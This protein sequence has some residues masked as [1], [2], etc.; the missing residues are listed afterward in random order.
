M[1]PFVYFEESTE[2]VDWCF[3]SLVFAEVD[4]SHLF[5]YAFV[6]FL[7]PAAVALCEYELSE[8][9]EPGHYLI[10]GRKRERM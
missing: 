9:F 6:V 4:L 7:S 2:S 8:L 10:L 5:G 1:D 3:E